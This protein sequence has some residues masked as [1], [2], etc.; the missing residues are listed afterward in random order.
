MNTPHQDLLNK[1]LDLIVNDCSCSWGEIK[2]NYSLENNFKI[3]ALNNIKVRNLIFRALNAYKTLKISKNINYKF[4]I[5]RN[6][7]S[8][9]FLAY[10]GKKNIAKIGVQIFV[11]S[12]KW[13]RNIRLTLSQ[14]LHLG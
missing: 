12:Q 6:I 2:K 5:S 4:I 14:E 11:N 9:I 3:I 10:F 8:S 13:V 7:F 1:S